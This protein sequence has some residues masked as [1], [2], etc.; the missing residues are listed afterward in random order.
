MNTGEKI[1]RL[2]KENNYTQEFPNYYQWIVKI[3][4]KLL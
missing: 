1:A 3:I 2:R 4:E